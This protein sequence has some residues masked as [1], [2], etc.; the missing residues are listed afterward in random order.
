MMTKTFRRPSQQSEAVIAH[1]GAAQIPADEQPL[2]AELFGIDQ[3]QRHAKAIAGWHEINP[4]KDGD[5]LLRRLAE[6]EQ[7][8][9]HAYGLVTEAAESERRVTPAAEWLLDNSYLIED[10]I[11]MA[12]RHLPQRYSRELPSLLSGARAGF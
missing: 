11:R 10:Q 8:L 4:R 2:R 3:L 1:R 5:I 7:V 12:K 9:L 6:N